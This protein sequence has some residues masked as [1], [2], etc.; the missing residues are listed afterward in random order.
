MYCDVSSNN[1]LDPDHS[2]S[3]KAVNLLFDAYIKD[4]RVYSCPSQPTIGLLVG[5]SGLANTANAPASANLTNTMTKY[6]FQKAQR[7]TN[8]VGGL[9]GDFG[10]GPAGAN[11][12]NHGT[13]GTVG[14]G[15]NILVVG[16]SVEFLDSKTRTVSA[17]AD[18][19]FAV[20]A[21]VGDDDAF[22]K[23]D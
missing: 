2:T 18:D 1:G 12:Q 7:P 4:A 5:T 15:Q 14:V 8:A 17:G 6:G 3:L 16:G 9:A 10:T 11:S 19:I 23:N 21:A 22:I 20:T 13:S